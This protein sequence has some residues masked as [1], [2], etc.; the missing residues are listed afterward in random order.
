MTYAL[1]SFINRQPQHFSAAICLDMSAQRL[2]FPPRC[3]GCPGYDH[4]WQRFDGY[5]CN[6][7]QHS[8][9]RHDADCRDGQDMQAI[10]TRMMG[11]LSL[12][13]YADGGWEEPSLPEQSPPLQ[14][15]ATA[16]SARPL[17]QTR[18]GPLPTVPKS[19]CSRG[20]AGGSRRRLHQDSSL[21][22]GKTICTNGAI[23]KGTGNC[24]SGKKACEHQNGPRT[25]LP[26]TV[27]RR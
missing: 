18:P 9:G 21:V 22:D 25:M 12:E 5:C 14:A 6:V 7:C 8:P 17:R 13:E 3:K 23:S 2:G 19:G 10:R 26:L 27:R 4:T 16:Q 15:A 11:T 24:P 1:L 20:S